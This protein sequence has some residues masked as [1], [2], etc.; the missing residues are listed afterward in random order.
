MTSVAASPSAL[1]MQ[2]SPGFFETLGITLTR[3]RLFTDADRN[4]APLVAI[5]NETMEKTLWPGKSAIGG[6][7]K[8]LNPTSPWATVVG[9]VRMF[10]K[11]DSSWKR[12][13]RCTSRTLNRDSARTPGRST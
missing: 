5:V 13:R 3:G 8:M 10:V 1:P 9:V 12:R 6:T 2:M 11:E 7:V 4:G